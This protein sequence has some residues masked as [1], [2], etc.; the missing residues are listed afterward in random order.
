MGLLQMVLRGLAREVDAL[1]ETFQLGTPM[2]F[3][4]P[5]TL[6]ESGFKCFPKFANVYLTSFC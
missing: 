4:G 3:K 5:P 2:L 1:S 6:L